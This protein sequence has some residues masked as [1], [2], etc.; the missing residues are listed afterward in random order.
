MELNTIL[1][2]AST[3]ISAIVGVS[4]IF[5]VASQKAKAKREKEQRDADKETLDELWELTGR[6]KLIEY[7]LDCICRNPGTHK[8]PPTGNSE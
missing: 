4:G 7:R 3:I 1:S 6:L 8:C 2:A 5:F